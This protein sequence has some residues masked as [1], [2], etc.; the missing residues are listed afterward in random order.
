MEDKRTIIL[1]QFTT[2]QGGRPSDTGAREAL[3][4][5][6]H[7]LTRRSTKKFFGTFFLRALS[8]H[9][10]TRRSTATVNLIDRI[11][12]AFNSRPHKEVDIRVRY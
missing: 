10:L 6:I 8:I 1:F 11:M 2:S 3:M 9:D 5:S 7:D 12:R 4:L